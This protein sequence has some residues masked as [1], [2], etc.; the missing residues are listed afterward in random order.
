MS[1]L[2][3]DLSRWVA[4]A[5]PRTL[6]LTVTPVV[7]GIALAV[8]TTGELH[9]VTALATL[10]AAAAIQIGTNLHN[11]A[12]DFVRG[13]DTPD[14]IGPPRAAAQGWF[15]PTQVKRAAHLAFFTAFVLGAL[16]CLRGGW[17]I[18]LLG[19]SALAAGYAYTGGPWPIAYGPFGEVFVL[20]FFGVAAVAGSHYLQTLDFSPTALALGTILGLPAAAVLLINNYRDLE[21]DRRG[22]RLTL[23]HYLGR[24]DARRL[25][26]FLLLAP[27]PLLLLLPLPLQPWPL[28]VALPFAAWLVARL[29]Q[30]A[31]GTALNPQLG[32]TA[33]YQMALVALLMVGLALHGP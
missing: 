29:N 10:L 8:T 4:A 30:G 13:N 24:E 32:A 3:R 20:L 26:A 15:T 21:T 5:R 14:R 18:L 2:A 1:G 11:D 28:I 22:G 31:L 23:C 25:Y 9:L 6:P 19:L 12:C 27:L 33:L 7:A 16:L 17:P